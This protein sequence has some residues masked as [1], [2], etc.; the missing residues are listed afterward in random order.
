M[1]TKKL[2]LTL[3]AAAVVAGFAIPATMDAGSYRSRIDGTCGYCNKAVYS[4]YQPIGYDRAGG[5]VYNWVT[6]HHTS[7]RSN[8]QGSQQSRSSYTT[9]RS[10]PSVSINFGIVPSYYGS[11][12]GYSRGGYGYSRGG[13]GGYGGF[14][15]YRS[16]GG[17][18]HCH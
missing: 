18:G 10:R 16:Y 5:S 11:S 4:Y 12:Y 14:S 2:L 17:G 15:G 3:T 7:C 8:Y 6:S 13:Y 9:T 1:N